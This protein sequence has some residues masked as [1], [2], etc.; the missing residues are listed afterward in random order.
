MFFRL[1]KGTPD[2][3]QWAVWGRERHQRWVNIKDINAKLIAILVISLEDDYSEQNSY[4]CNLGF[5]M[6]IEVTDMTLAQKMG[7]ICHTV[8][9]HYIF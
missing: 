9:G 8:G 5:I 6:Y 1:T 3:N 2:R 7:C 4:H